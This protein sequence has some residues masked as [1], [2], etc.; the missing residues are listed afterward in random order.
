MPNDSSVHRVNS[1]VIDFRRG[2]VLTANGDEVPLRA[3][4]FALLRLMIA[5]RGKLLDH[6]TISKAIWPN[7]SVT[8]ESISRCVSD[9]RKALGD[10]AHQIV[11]TI[12]RRGY[13]LQS[14]DV[15]KPAASPEAAGDLA[16]DDPRP[17]IAVLPFINLGFEQDLGYLVDGIVDGVIA[18]LSRFPSFLVLDRNSTYRY[19]DESPDGTIVGTKLRVRYVL[20]GSIQKSGSRVRINGRLIDAAKSTLLWA[21]RSERSL[22]DVFQIQDE[23]TIGVAAAVEP[24]IRMAEV[25][26]ALRKPTDDLEAYDLVLRAHH[27][28]ECMDSRGLAEAAHLCRQAIRLDPAYALAYAL[29]GR[30]IWAGASLHISKLSKDQIRECVELA[31][32]AVRLGAANTDALTFAALIVALPGR[33][34]FEGIRISQRAIVQNPNSANALA[35]SGMLHAYLGDTTSALCLL[36]QADYISPAGMRID[37]RQ[38]GFIIANFVDENYD[39]VLTWSADAL[40]EQPNNILALRYRTAA[41]GL[42]GCNSAAR[43]SAARLIQ[44]NSTLTLARATYHLE[45]EMGSPF[46]KSQVAKAYIEGLRIAGIPER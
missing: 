16:H 36:K 15:R 8:D 28:F 17:S 37:Y 34:I 25:T 5:N 27:A 45:V 41:L 6:E 4:S 22:A 18:A 1:Y 3:K 2:A 31:R 40:S 9:I 43:Q 20:H 26:R 12:P 11:K 7:I 35:M 21:G 39:E 29:L 24:R 33:E 44:L 38:I 42:A 14:D 30:I 23:L 32:T 13:I 46:R 19:R 10:A